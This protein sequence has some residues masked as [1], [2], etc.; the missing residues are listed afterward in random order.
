MK[1]ESF[2]FNEI[3]SSFSYALDLTEGQPPGH[4]IRS[5]WIGFHIAQQLQL[6]TSELWDIYYTLLM[7][8]TGCSSNAARICELYGTND[9]ELKHAFK[10]V[11]NDEFGQLAKFVLANTG[12][13]SNLHQRIKS[14]LNIV[15]NGKDIQTELIHTRCTRGA[16]IARMIGLNETIAEGIFNLDEHFNGNGQPNGLS[17]HDI[18]LGSRIALLSQVADVFYVAAGREASIEQVRKRSNTWFDPELV[19]IFLHVTKD[20]NFWIGLSS[21]NIDE[22]VMDLE[23]Q[24]IRI[25]VTEETLDQV[26]AAFGAIVDAK[27]PYTAGHSRRVGIYTSSLGKHLGFDDDDVRWLYRGG[28]LH[29]LGKLGVSNTLLDKSGNL[30]DNEW[31]QMKKHPMFTEEI[32]HRFGPFKRLATITGAHHE[33]MDGKGYYKGLSGDQISLESRIITTADIFDACISDRPYRKGMP[34][35]KVLSI[36]DDLRGIA[37]DDRCMDVVH[38]LGEEWISIQSNA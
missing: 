31:V 23:P 14:L 33:R 30:V 21:D 2:S 36:M 13:D 20:D 17:G 35:E 4:C 6:S 9:H 37:I 25:E 15:K 3:L 10:F 22:L 5:C 26:S 8:D 18:P 29:D 19:K 11:N 7:K 12:K 32:L 16:E 28:L 34:L 38:T 24:S 27:S 1:A